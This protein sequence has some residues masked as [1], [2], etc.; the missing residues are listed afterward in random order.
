MNVK[1]RLGVLALSTMII[2]SGCSTSADPYPQNEDKLVTQVGKEKTEVQEVQDEVTEEK[3]EIDLQVVK[4]NE[5]GQI[6]VLMYHAIGEP[7][8]EFTRTPE[9]LR[10]DLQYF[11]ENGYRPISLQDYLSGNITTEA[12]YTP[13]VLTF[14]DGWQNNF[15]LIQDTKGDWIIDPNSAVAIL[16]KF[17]E[18]HPDFPLEATFFVNDNIPFE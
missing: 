10:K 16:E 1:K 15:S 17:N 12:G 9:N 5:A 14:D 18:E 3:K 4:P 7:E 13:I 2:L 11:Y 6:M 8:A